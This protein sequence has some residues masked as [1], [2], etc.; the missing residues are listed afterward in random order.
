MRFST[1]HAEVQAEG[2]GQQASFTI[3]ASGKAFKGLIDGLYS[4]KIEAVIRELATN[5][6]DAHKA[7]GSIAPFEVHLPTPL[8]PTF[9]LRDFGTGM[10]H[11]LMM[12]RYTT[13]FDSTK[14]GLNAE[15]DAKVSADDQVGMLGLG[16]KAFFSYTDSCTISVWVDG[17]VRHYTVF[18]GADGIPQIALA[19][20]APS[21]EPVGVRVQFA[22]KT[23]DFT[24]FENAAIR[25]FK[26]FPITPNGLPIKAR[27]AIT[28]EP[29]EV[30]GFWKSYA[31]DYLPN[32]G[33]YARQGC[34][35]YPIDLGQI[36]E[37]SIEI[38]E[39]EWDYNTQTTKSVRK[40]ELSENFARF[41]DMNQTVVID[42]PIGSLEFDLSRERLAY[43]DRTII[44]LRRRWSDFIDD[45]DAVF[46][47]TFEP[48]VTGWEKL[49][50]SSVSGFAKMGVLFA[51]SSYFTEAEALMER[52]LAEMPKHKNDR[53]FGDHAFF[54]ILKVDGGQRAGRPGVC[55]YREAYGLPRT[56]ADDDWAKT[57]IVYRD[58]R[59]AVNVNMRVNQYLAQNDLVYAFMLDEG[60]LTADLY[61]RIGRPPIVRLSDMPMLP[62][63]QGVGGGD[64]PPP[65]ERIKLIS[66]SGHNYYGAQEESQYEGHLFAFLNCGEVVNPDPEKYPNLTTSEVMSMHHI[67]KHFTGRSISFINVKKNEFA[68]LD[69]WDSYPLFYGCLEGILDRISVKDLRDFANLLN[70]DRFNG[71]KY[72]TALKRYAAAM[73]GQDSDPLLD[74]RRFEWRYDR[75]QAN[76]RYK[77]SQMIDGAYLKPF[78]DEI[79][80][81]ARA[82]GFEV[83]PE[84]HGASYRVTAHYPYPL[85]PKRWEKLVHMINRSPNMKDQDRRFIY[86]AIKDKLGC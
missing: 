34:V 33:F 53:G 30:G 84:M 70:W 13:M 18:M 11:D 16:S 10:S 43:T 51:S 77:L 20:Q 1:G 4:R 6:F 86:N 48:L 83:L 55:Y 29:A 35:L 17:E 76:R 75:M 39:D 25:V 47:E 23:K 32:G 8:Q 64:G 45:L 81:R 37:R 31:K 82:A 2:F 52:I 42:F 21:D 7:A 14:D 60:Y 9:W 41:K 15:D 12:R 19:G 57:I 79:I 62:K 50:A 80:D 22:V 63:R 38:E 65:F 78:R 5:A 59:K 24:E 54:S 71:T 56:L 40:T 61:K 85:L 44:A 3:A 69:K 66:D 26:G 27:E 36:D 67:L 58:D 49:Q 46:A 68:K 74:M 73:R 72:H 28:T